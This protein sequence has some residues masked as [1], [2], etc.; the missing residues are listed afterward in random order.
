MANLP[1]EI[2]HLLEEIQ[3]KDQ[4]LHECHNAIASRDNSIQKFIKLNGSHLV[5]PKEEAYAK[6]ILQNYERAQTLQDE[7]V[8]LSEKAAVL[9]S[10]ISPLPYT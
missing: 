3:A 2:H 5:N 4:V 7:K 1:A 8:A 9:V 10:D 6:T